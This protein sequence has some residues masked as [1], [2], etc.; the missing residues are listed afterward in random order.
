MDKLQKLLNEHKDKLWGWLYDIQLSNYN[1]TDIWLWED[2]EWDIGNFIRMQ[3]LSDLLFC[4]P[5]LS[6]LNW[7]YTPVD[8][9]LIC[10]DSNLYRD[11][12]VYEQTSQ[13]LTESDYHKINLCLLS[14]DEERIIYIENNTL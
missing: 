12:W 14:T 8:R 9:D 6:W 5:F 7:L 3:S 10:W 13:R 2:V 11:D 4:T 1:S